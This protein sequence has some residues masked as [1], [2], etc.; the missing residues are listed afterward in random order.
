MP[1]SKVIRSI[2]FSPDNRFFG[3]AAE[4]GYTIWSLPDWNIYHDVVDQLTSDIAFSPDG[5]M[6]AIAK[7]KGIILWD[8]ETI[9]PIA[10]LGTGGFLGGTVIAFSPDGNT[11]ASGGY[12]GILQLWDVRGYYEE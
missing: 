3:L 1:T 7:A 5:T 6:F 10:L 9:T 8:I 11:L 2:E 4:N 12:G